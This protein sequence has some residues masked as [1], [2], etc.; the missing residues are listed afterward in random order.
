MDELIF[1]Q[2]WGD[3]AKKIWTELH[4]GACEQADEVFNLLS[5]T[6]T[7]KS[8]L[9]DLP[10]DPIV[11]S[12][13]LL[14][15]IFNDIDSHRYEIENDLWATIQKKII[16]SVSYVVWRSNFYDFLPFSGERSLDLIAKIYVETIAK[17]INAPNNSLA[18][19]I[20]LECGENFVV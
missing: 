10:T 15:K 8:P 5:I 13:E 6:P 9:A 11:T 16:C 12:S 3:S 17:I 2:V 20:S 19:F 4:A 18:G 7:S 1:K 14:F